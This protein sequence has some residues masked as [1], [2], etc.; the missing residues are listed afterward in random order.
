MGDKIRIRRHDYEV[1]G[2]ARRMVSS[3]GDPMV[4]IPSR[5]RRKRSS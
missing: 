2:L 5:T 4:F 1:V 3:G